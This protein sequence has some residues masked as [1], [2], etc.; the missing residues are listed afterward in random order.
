M[1]GFTTRTLRNYLNQGVLNGEKVDGVWQFSAENLDR[2]FNEPFVKE[3]LRI[4][5]SSVVFDFLSDMQKSSDR[6]CIILDLHVSMGE[7]NAVSGFF[8]EQIKEAHDIMFNYGWD[9]GFSRI[10]LSGDKQQVG[11]IMTAYHER[12]EK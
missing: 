5:R 8:C 10:I 6:A 11:M 7:G 2:F 3:G 4:K 9:N 1:T 12:Y